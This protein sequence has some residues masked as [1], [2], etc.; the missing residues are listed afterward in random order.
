MEKCKTLC[1]QNSRLLNVFFKLQ[2]FKEI[3]GTYTVTNPQ[4]LMAFKIEPTVVKW[5]RKFS[6]FG[7]GK[8]KHKLLCQSP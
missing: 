7:V 5:L 6:S 4:R 8:T 3:E 1:E 2:V